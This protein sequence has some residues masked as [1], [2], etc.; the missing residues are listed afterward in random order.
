F[1]PGY[2]EATMGEASDTGGKLASKPADDP[3]SAKPSGFNSGT[4]NAG[5]KS[6][7]TP[8]STGPVAKAPT[9]DKKGTN[10]HHP[11]NGK[12]LDIETR[13]LERAGARMLDEPEVHTSR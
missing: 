1:L 9:A 6:T 2:R 5:A 7:S 11:S 8:E 3:A 13:L 4:K 12:T 10:G